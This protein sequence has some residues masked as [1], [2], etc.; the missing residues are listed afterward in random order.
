TGAPLVPPAADTDP[1]PAPASVAQ[2][3]EARLVWAWL[4]EPGV[5]LIDAS[6]SVSLPATPVRH[7]ER[8][9]V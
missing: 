2:A 8:I 5:R 1:L 7:L 3:E 6:G 4:M 9:A